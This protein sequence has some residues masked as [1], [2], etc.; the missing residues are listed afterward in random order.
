MCPVAPRWPR[1]AK[2]RA[3]PT[4]HPIA[5]RRNTWPHGGPRAACRCERTRYLA[6]G[7]PPM[8]PVGTVA[9]LGTVCFGCPIFAKS[10]TNV[11]WGDQGEMEWVSSAERTEITAEVVEQAGRLAFFGIHP[12]TI[13]LMR[14]ARTLKVWP[15][16][17]CSRQDRTSA[18]ILFRASLLIARR[19]LL[20]LFPCLFRALR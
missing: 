4:I 6:A 12:A 1:L 16:R 11:S 10:I 20:K 8:G 18:L 17:R 13:G 15:V 14:R 5:Q 19:N 3:V 2:R 9:P 7:P